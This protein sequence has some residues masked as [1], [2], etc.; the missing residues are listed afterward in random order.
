MNIETFVTVETTVA[1]KKIENEVLEQLEKF[2][3]SMQ[4]LDSVLVNQ[5][6]AGSFT[7]HNEYTDSDESEV[8]N[9]FNT[10]SSLMIAR[11]GLLD[12]AMLLNRWRSIKDNELR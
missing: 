5:I 1:I 6:S 9:L 10:M 3:T 12:D 7:I 2:M 4:N 11:W 8:T